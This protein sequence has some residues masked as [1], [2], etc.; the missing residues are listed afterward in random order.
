MI[1]YKAFL[2]CAIPQE[3]FCRGHITYSIR[4][5]HTSPRSAIKS[6]P[7]PCA[8]NCTLPFCPHCV[9][10][11]MLVAPGWASSDCSS[12]NQG[13]VFPLIRRQTVSPCSLRPSRS[14]AEGWWEHNVT[15]G[16]KR[17]QP[18]VREDLLWCAMLASEVHIHVCVSARDWGQRFVRTL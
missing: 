14:A 7:A 12:D 3:I 6:S 15:M 2:G 13:I 10:H 1:L 16:V 5:Y 17:W 11:W 9:W 8:S 18:V 4:S